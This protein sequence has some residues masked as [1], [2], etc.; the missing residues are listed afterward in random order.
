MAGLRPWIL[1]LVM[2]ILGSFCIMAFAFSFIQQ[3]NPSSDIFNLQYGLNKSINNMQTSLD[4]FTTTSDSVKKI[5]EDANPSPLD[6]VFLIFLGAFQ[7]PKA[8]LFFIV[9]GVNSLVSVIVS[10]IGGFTGIV[11][12]SLLEGTLVMIGSVLIDA[13]I[14]TAIFLIIKAIRSGESER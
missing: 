5:L 12:G 8:F 7:I 11:P 3:T 1:S 9:G 4:S 2:V 14:V 13:M 10:L 6:Y